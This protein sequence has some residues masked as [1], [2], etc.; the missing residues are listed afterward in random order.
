MAT[1]DIIIL[2]CFIPAII[3]GLQKGFIEQAVALLSLVL[4]AWLAFHFSDIVCGWLSQYIN[5]PQGL[6]K[7]IGFLF[8]LIITAILLHLL[9]NLLTKVFKFALLGWLNRLFGVMF[10]LTTAILVIGLLLIVFQSINDTIGLVSK[11]AIE[12]SVLFEPV[13]DIAL[14]VFPY[15]KALIFKA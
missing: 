9:G 10:A 13:K 14:K 12:S 6:M 7:A 3:R 15:L 11:E 8:I 4:G 5:A 1:L 2:I